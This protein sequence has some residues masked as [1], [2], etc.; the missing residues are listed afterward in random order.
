MLI[1]I[2]RRRAVRVGR[3]SRG[4]AVHTRRLMRE[5]H[6]IPVTL[7]VT[8]PHHNTRCPN[9]QRGE[10]RRVTDDMT[11]TLTFG[12]LLRRQIIT[13]FLYLLQVANDNLSIR[14]GLANHQTTYPGCHNLLTC[15]PR[16]PRNYS[17]YSIIALFCLFYFIIHF[18][19]YFIILST[20]LGIILV[21]VP[22]TATSVPT[23]NQAGLPL[24]HRKT[25]ATSPSSHNNLVPWNT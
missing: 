25:T 19:I 7:G 2:V 18:I 20:L 9:Q 23:C 11:E 16:Q 4:H 17:R 14:I 8:H 1:T 10:K 13:L 5:S 12:A 22:H 3:L 24:A 6:S 21:T 15:L